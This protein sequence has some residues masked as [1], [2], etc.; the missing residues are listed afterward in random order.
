M[1]VKLRVSDLAKRVG[2]SPDTIRYYER[3]G[4]LPPPARTATDYRS[5]DHSAVDRLQFIQGAQRLG[6][7]LLDIK[8]LLAVRDTGTCPCEPAGEL[9]RKRVEEID[10]EMDKLTVLRS[11]LTAMVARLPSDDCPQP[12]PGTW[13]PRGEEVSVMNCD[14]CDD[15]NCT[16]CC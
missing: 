9:L 15:P 6:L 13:T 7:R 2:V 4:L 10:A 5:Y 1:T 3:V 14:C 11:D 8:T 16:C 12:A